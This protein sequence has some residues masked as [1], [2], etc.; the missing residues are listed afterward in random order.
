MRSPTMLLF[1]DIHWADTSQL[2]L[3]ETLASRV[4]DVPVLFV[5][6]ARP[7]L[8]GD[9]PTWG[10]G[11][12]AYT[13]LPLDPLTD[14]SSQ[15]ARGAAPRRTSRRARC[16]RRWPRWPRATRS[17]SRSSPRR[18]PSDRPSDELPTSVRGIIA[19]RLD[20]LP[21][22]ERT[23]LVDASVAGRV[24]WRGAL[25]EMTHARRPHGKPQR[26]RAPRPDRTRGRVS[27]QGRPAVR[28]QA[29]SD[30]RRRVPDA[31]P[32]RQTRT[33]RGRRPLPLGER[34]RPASH[35]RLSRATGAKRASRIGRSTSSSPRQ[36][37]PGAGGP[38]ITPSPSTRRHSSS[39][40]TTSNDG[41][42]SGCKQCVMV[43]AFAHMVQDDVGRPT[44]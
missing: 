11:L 15:A 24:F 5:A 2:D 43:Q 21:P 35:T 1:E 32:G 3:L 12:P 28:L 19:A 13:A 6:L 26:A 30:P 18:S 16:R 38:R 20:S 25:A 29:R 40:A 4:R 44:D 7:E 36:S 10:G 14:D 9:R 22:G 42:R 39:S 17:S 33:S 8:L 31:S 41:A 34:R 37:S 23:V 27:D